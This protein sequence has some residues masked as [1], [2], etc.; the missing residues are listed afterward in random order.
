M[1]EENEQ[2]WKL[3]T[4]IKQTSEHNVTKEKGLILNNALNNNNN[5]AK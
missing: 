2:N 4:F 5:Q 1:R 3:Q